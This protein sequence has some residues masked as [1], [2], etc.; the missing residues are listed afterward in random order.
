[1]V[2]GVV[3]GNRGP[4]DNEPSTSAINRGINFWIS[5]RMLELN[6]YLE[7]NVLSRRQRAQYHGTGANGGRVCQNRKSRETGRGATGLRRPAMRRCARR[8]PATTTSRS[9][10]R[11]TGRCPDA[12]R[13][14]ALDRDGGEVTLAGLNFFSDLGLDLAPELIARKWR[15]PGLS[16]AASPAQSR[17]V[18]AA[19]ASAEDWR[20]GG[21]RPPSGGRFSRRG[22]MVALTCVNG[23]ASFCAGWRTWCGCS[24]S[25][26]IAMW[27]SR[28]GGTATASA[29]CR[30]DAHRR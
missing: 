29:I 3:N 14:V 28:H 25:Q 11:G 2:H 4:A 12:T 6:D 1:M 17:G 20:E 15:W 30:R 8:A 5:L 24:T 9:A 13:P 22:V 19:M 21:V 10:R 26:S 7:S 16:A 27:L 23:S 18:R